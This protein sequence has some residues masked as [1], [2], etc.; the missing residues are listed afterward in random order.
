MTTPTYPTPPPRRIVPTPSPIPPPSVP[1]STHP[2]ILQFTPS[3]DPLADRLLAE[4]IIV[5]SGEID[6]EVAYRVVAQLLLLA[7][8]SATADIA[9]YISSPGGSVTAAMA[10]HDAMRHVRPDIA[11]WAV[12]FAVGTGQF[13]LSAGTPGKRHALPH[14]RI[15]L[16]RPTGTPSTPSG[17][18]GELAREMT[19]LTA[20]YTG[21]TLDQIHDDIEQGRWFT[22]AEARACGLV[23]HVG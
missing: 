4:R 3:A 2:P 6:D 18:H 21:R 9:L 19:E 10:I 16:H 20:R 17:V 11:T 5:L 13:L 23:D 14:A 22:A 12:G 1:T 8:E 15:R 7:A